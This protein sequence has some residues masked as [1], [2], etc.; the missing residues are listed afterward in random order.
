MEGKVLE[1]KSGICPTLLC[2]HA[3]ASLARD[4]WALKPLLFFTKDGL[5]EDIH[6]WNIDILNQSPL[7]NSAGGGG[8]ENG[9]G[10]DDNHEKK[11]EFE[12]FIRKSKLYAKDPL[13]CKVL[14]ITSEMHAMAKVAIL[15]YI[16]ELKWWKK[17]DQFQS[18]IISF[19]NDLLLREIFTHPSSKKINSLNPA[20]YKL[21]KDLLPFT[22]DN[23]RLEFLGDSILKFCASIY[24][25]FKYPKANEGELTTRRSELTNNTY[26]LEKCN[27]WGIIELLRYSSTEDIKKPKADV[28]EAMFGAIFLERGF[29]E[30][31]RFIVHTVY[32]DHQYSTLPTFKCNHSFERQLSSIQSKFLF[33]VQVKISKVCLL[34]DAITCLGDQNYSYQRLEFLG[35]SYLDGIVSHFLYREF[36]LENEGF[37]SQARALLV[38][39]EALAQISQRIKLYQLVT[40]PSATFSTKR[41]GDLFEAFIG[42]V[43]LDNELEDTKKLIYRLL[44]LNKDYVVEILEAHYASSR[45]VPHNSTE[46]IPDS[47]VLPVRIDQMLDNQP[48]ASTIPPKKQRN[49][50][51]LNNSPISSAVSI[52]PESSSSSTLSSPPV[53]TPPITINQGSTTPPMTVTSTSIMDVDVQDKQDEQVQ[54]QQQVI[55]NVEE[56]QKEM[57]I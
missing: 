19:E 6:R 2:T 14:G 55:L 48:I 41:L 25:F 28:M 12:N 50:I 54:Q 38:R 53:I 5:R 32:N 47:E 24:L 18:N 33:D 36:P 11:I 40:D 22:T 34:E 51:Y 57:T 49:G 16:P 15:V 42:G 39:N 1:L 20:E 29:K 45:P 27:E 31:Y 7:L 3:T 46:M 30:V 44:N 13:I 35:D 9:S 43:L 17:V 26:L 4:Y 56:E 8:G 52:S 10:K 23:Q 21:F 37:L